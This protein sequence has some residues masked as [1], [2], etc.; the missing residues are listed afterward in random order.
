MVAGLY[1]TN[2]IYAIFRSVFYLLF[3]K[4]YTMLTGNRYYIY[5]MHIINQL[6]IHYQLAKHLSFRAEFISN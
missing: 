1:I 5:N 3:V 6:T 2:E 4:I